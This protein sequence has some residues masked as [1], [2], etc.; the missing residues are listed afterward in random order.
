MSRTST[1]EP[2]LS[3]RPSPNA[4][5]TRRITDVLSKFL[6]D[7]FVLYTKTRNFH[8]NVTGSRFFILHKAFEEQYEALNEFVD[9][10]AEQIRA[11]R[12]QPPATLREF[13][14]GATIR[15]PPAGLRE[16]DVEMVR[17]LVRNHDD[18][19]SRTSQAVIDLD[20]EE[21]HPG[22]VDLLTE[23]VRFHDKTSWMLRSQLE[24]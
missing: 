10:I 2:R 8:W 24:A 11:L 18:L 1:H 12:S 7:E 3:Q 5:A 13:L 15:E 14:D 19:L 16:S 20:G 6:C 17:D 22:V 9:T 23:L 4:P 21:T